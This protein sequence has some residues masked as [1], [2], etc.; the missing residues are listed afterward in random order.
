MP[1]AVD[2]ILSK[3]QMSVTVYLN[4]PSYLVV[5][6]IAPPCICRLCL[7]GAHRDRA[8]GETVTGTHFHSWEHNK[9]KGQK[10]LESLQ[11]LDPEQPQVTDRD[12]AIAWF[13]QRNDIQPLAVNDMGW[14]LD[15]G[16]F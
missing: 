3:I 11:H 15:Q 1:I 10:L 5:M 12:A 8:T 14:P 13:L 4:D 16:F 6:L 2:G 9:P 7:T